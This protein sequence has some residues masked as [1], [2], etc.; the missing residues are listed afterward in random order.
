MKQ[1]NERF[2]IGM[3]AS[4]RD[5]M[6][7]INLGSAGIAIIVDGQRR[8]LGTIT[9]GDIRRAIL[10][11]VDLG[12]PASSIMRTDPVT[13]PPDADTQ[14]LRRIFIERS[15]KHI[16]VVDSGNRF[17]ELVQVS[18]LLSIPLSNPDITDRECRAVLEV[19][20]SSNLS[21]GPKVV[22]FERKIASY[23]GRRHA[24]AV[25]SG[26]SGLHL[27]VKSLGLGSG[28]EVITTPF[29]FIA[30]SNCLLY[31][32]VKPVF[33]DIEPDTYNID[34]ELIERAITKRTRAILAV[35]VF[36][37]P[38][39]YDALD[40]LA[41][42]H[43]LVVISD[44]CESIGSVYKGRP[45]GSFG[46]AGVFAFYPNKQITTGEGGA[47]VTNDD[48]LAALCRSFRNQGR[49]EKG[50]WLAHERLGY[51]YRLSD[52]SSALGI[53]QLDRIEEIV[54]K[55]RDVAATYGRLLGGVKELRLPFID[56][57]V[58]RMSW[59]VYVVQLA[60]KFSRSERDYIVQHLSRAGIGANTYFQPIH[61]QP[62]YV[63]RFGFK[64]GD[65]PI[66]ESIS[67]RTIALPFHNQLGADSATIVA[68]RLI[69]L[70]NDVQACRAC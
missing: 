35:D 27:V 61:L 60:E 43:G 47:I 20:Q 70:I 31:E 5:A 36:G 52:I 9:D 37:Q 63:E 48:K 25:N 15:L 62:F 46:V 40:R 50:G 24:I 26:T 19:L 28:D 22:E 16:P 59:F 6:E 33:V 69:A 10:K 57:G 23:A 68:Q 66:T 54:Q 39:R 67:Q 7:A 55:R 29:S 3:T 34:P 18:D 30:S 4:I 58:D 17:I 56:P 65:F 53:V 11:G 64:E 8:L 38:A 51:N 14:H 32:G 12:A 21:L 1:N 13:V 44:C 42:K 41:Q 49:G 45:A 2:V